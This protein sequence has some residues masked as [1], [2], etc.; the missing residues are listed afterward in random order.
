[1]TYKKLNGKEYKTHRG[2]IEK[3][4]KHFFVTDNPTLENLLLSLVHEYEVS[5]NEQRRIEYIDNK[6][7]R[8]ATLMPKIAGSEFYNRY[9][10]M[11]NT[12]YDDNK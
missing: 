10:Q 11:T 6:A 2:S 4:G 3:K 5:N 1:M 12:K 8:I 9:V 7:Y